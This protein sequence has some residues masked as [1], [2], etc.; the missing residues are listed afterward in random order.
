L[1]VMAMKRQ[2]PEE[3]FIK[4]DKIG[5]GSFGEVF[6]GIDKSTKAEVAIKIIDLEDAEDEIEDIQQ[7]IAMLSQCDCPYVTKYY[8]A[9]LKGTKLW[10]VMEFL[11]G[12]SVLDL[13]KPGPLDEQYCAIILRELLRALAYLHDE[14][15]IHRDIKAANVLL[16]SNGSVKLADFGVAGQLTDQMTKRNTFVGTP[17]W[18]AP[19]V[20]KQA[21]YDSK[22]DIWSTG[23]TAIEL[24]KGEPPYSDL[25]PMRVL[26]LIPKNDPPVLEGSFSK[27]FKDFV[28]LC[29]KKDPDGRPTA[30]ELLKHKFIK[31]AKKTQS[32]VELVDRYRR[33]KRVIGD[34]DDGDEDEDDNKED[35]SNGDDDSWDFGTVKP[36]KP[37]AGSSPAQEPVKPTHSA[38]A[39]EPFKPAQP[40]A[41][42]EP[43]KPAAAAQPAPAPAPVHQST[44]TA[45]EAALELQRAQ[46]T[47]VQKPG[48]KPSALTSVVY[49][50]LR[51][52]LKTHQDNDNVVATLAQLKIAFDNAESAQPG[53][54]HQI[55]ALIIETLKS[56][57]GQ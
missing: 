38:P 14:G 53:I 55:I 41:T 30:K 40:T 51:R 2:D 23:I 21:G 56:N 35:E 9:Y 52:L 24:A 57:K 7:E 17:F 26:F 47:A 39:Q 13:M 22:A 29:L 28:A 43:A 12:G 44:Q 15:K 32:L 20:I 46:P 42:K 10:I 11:A 34:D 8:G 5:K 37:A 50:V 19:E 16:A 49:P 36:K 18:M 45:A 1:L 27:N 3:L 25:H 48:Q 4:Q 33:W 31:S 54:S 6:K